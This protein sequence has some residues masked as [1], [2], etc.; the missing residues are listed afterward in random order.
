MNEN[1]EIIAHAASLISKA[2]LL[3][4]QDRRHK[5]IRPTCEQDVSRDRL[6]GLGENESQRLLRPGSDCQSAQ[7]AGCLALG[8]D[9]PKHPAEAETLK[10]PGSIRKASQNRRRTSPINSCLASQSRVV[11]RYHEGLVLGLVAD[12]DPG[13]H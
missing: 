8:L 12:S 13:G 9:C 11:S 7:I 10:E 1:L 6:D 4:A 5:A 2:A 3:A